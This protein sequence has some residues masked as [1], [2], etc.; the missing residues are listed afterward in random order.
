VTGAVLIAVLVA[1][2]VAIRR[3]WSGRKSSFGKTGLE[4]GRIMSLGQSNKVFPG[5][6][7]GAL[8]L[9]NSTEFRNH[10]FKEALLLHKDVKGRKLQGKRREFGGDLSN[11][12]GLSILT[13]LSDGLPLMPESVRRGGGDKVGFESLAK[14]VECLGVCGGGFPGTIPYGSMSRKVEPGQSRDLEFVFGG[15]EVH[16][17]DIV[18]DGEL[19]IVKS[20]GGAI[21]TFTRVVMGL[22]RLERGRGR[23]GSKMFG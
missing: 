4:E 6:V 8:G 10:C 9:D 19:P 14:I 22:G 16:E 7:I 17:L 5:C 12:S 15:I 20:N 13:G 23:H 11:R 3:R 18:F 1:I 21:L 2:L